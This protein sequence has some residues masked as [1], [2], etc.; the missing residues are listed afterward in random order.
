MATTNMR[1]DRRAL[2]RAG[3]FCG[4]ALRFG[5]STAAGSASSTL[6]ESSFDSPALGEAIRFN[7]YLPAGYAAEPERRYPLI[8]LLH[9][10]GDKMSAWTHV[11]PLLDS[12]IASGEVPPLIAVMPDAPWSRRGSYYVDSA[13]AEGR[14]VETALM[15]ELLPHI[16]A[17]YRTIVRR[18]ARAVGGYSMGGYGALRYALAWP[19]LFGAAL[20]MSP[21]V[22]TPLPPAGSSAREFGGFGRGSEGFVDEIYR[23]MNYPALLPGLAAR[24]QVMLIFITAGDDEYKNPDSAEAMH[25]I[26]M[27]AHLLFS[28]LSRTAN[29]E[30]ELRILQGGHDWPVWMPSF[31]EGLRWIAG[32]LGW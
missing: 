12:M 31:H 22:Y 29:V 20:V 6:L 7:V 8:Y 18:N 5:V 30:T 26:D 32:K 28:R 9:G 13:H 24:G 11:L 14:P 3:A 21:A 19:E 1:F 16:D 4:L 15:R 25:D 10:R 17:S 23:A 2:L 27:E